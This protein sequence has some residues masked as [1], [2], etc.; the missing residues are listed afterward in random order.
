MKLFSN[1]IS[2]QISLV[3]LLL[4]FY[5]DISLTECNSGPIKKLL[6]G[7]NTMIALKYITTTSYSTG[8][9][10]SQNMPLHMPLLSDVGVIVLSSNSVL[11]PSGTVLDCATIVF[12]ERCYVL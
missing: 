12:R 2:Q 9:L 10:L 5:D 11:T 4:T 1:N 3:V 7:V 8:T 6:F